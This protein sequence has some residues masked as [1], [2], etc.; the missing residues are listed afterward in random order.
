MNSQEMSA[1]SKVPMKRGD[2]PLCPGKWS[3]AL[4]PSHYTHVCI[5]L[6]L[7]NI[8][9]CSC[10]TNVQVL[11]ADA[12]FQAQCKLTLTG[13]ATIQMTRVQ[14]VGKRKERK[15]SL[16]PTFEF[17]IHDTCMH[18][19]NT[20][21]LQYYRLPS[22]CYSVVRHYNYLDTTHTHT[23]QNSLHHTTLRLRYN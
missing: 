21:S 2:T 1:Y 13:T 12:N 5:H 17:D 18:T 9:P 15:K 7:R 23:I 11:H 14:H 8:K 3:S 22:H 6:S 16:N 19:Y 10:T 20:H 4:A